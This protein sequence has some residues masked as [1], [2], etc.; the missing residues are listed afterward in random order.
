MSGVLPSIWNITPVPK[1]LPPAD[2]GDIRPIS[3]TPCVSKVLE[4]FVVQW[5]ISNIR[6][7]IDPC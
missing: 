4:E 7:T 1:I 5:M 3:L 6:D 2:E